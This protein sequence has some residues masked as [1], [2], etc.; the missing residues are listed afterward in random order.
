MVS[1]ISIPTSIIY[2]VKIFIILG[3]IFFPIII[4]MGLYYYLSAFINRK[5]KFLL[6]DNL[7]DNPLMF[8]YIFIIS[9]IVKFFIFFGLLKLILQSLITYLFFNFEDPNDLNCEMAEMSKKLA[10]V[11]SVIFFVIYEL[12]LFPFN[13]I[14]FFNKSFIYYI[15]KFI[16]ILIKNKTD[17]SNNKFKNLRNSLNSLNNDWTK[18][19]NTDIKKILNKATKDMADMVE[20]YPMKFIN[21]II[22]LLNISSNNNKKLSI[23]EEIE[24]NKNI[25]ASNISGR[26]TVPI[27]YLGIIYLGLYYLFTGSLFI[28]RIIIFILILIITM[29]FIYPPLITSTIING[30]VAFIFSIKNLNSSN[31]NFLKKIIDDFS[32]VKLDINNIFFAIF[33]LIKSEKN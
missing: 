2:I 22:N 5:I 3:L 28:I 20:S 21:I 18:Y 29:L 33:E 8:K 12:I 6:F 23:D 9:I 11:F 13:F 26:I 14:I 7:K 27:I 4:F 25:I 15:K 30:F 1:E 19:I 32:I 24:I 31:N 16:N 17:E 10:T